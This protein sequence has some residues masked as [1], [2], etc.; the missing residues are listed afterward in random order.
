MARLTKEDKSFMAEMDAQTLAEARVIEQDKSR[1]DRAK[2]VAGR[3]AED[4]KERANAMSQISG[5]STSQNKSSDNAKRRTT[6]KPANPLISGIPGA[7]RR[8]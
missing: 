5:R 2:K 1:L 3:M 8:R 6:Q 4:A 7:G